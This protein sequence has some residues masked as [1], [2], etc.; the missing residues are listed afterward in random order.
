VTG[1][2]GWV[3]AVGAGRRVDYRVIAAPDFLV[4]GREY[5]VLGD[6]VCP[7]PGAPHLSIARTTT[8]V[9]G[10]LTVVYSTQVVSGQD[11]ADP[12]G[13]SGMVADIRDEQ[14]RPL[15]LIYGF[16]G[17]GGADPTPDA[18]DLNAARAEA[19]RAYRAFL[20]DE[21]GFAV[22]QTAPLQLISSPSTSVLNPTGPLAR[23]ES[24]AATVGGA[25]QGTRR[26]L[27]V[28]LG[29]ILAVAVSVTIAA[30]WLW[31]SSPS[32]PVAITNQAGEQTGVQSTALL[33]TAV[34]PRQGRTVP[35][36]IPMPPAVSL[37]PVGS[38]IPTPPPVAEQSDPACG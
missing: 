5:G 37:P 16:V 30:V 26:N 28:L 23:R 31:P 29:L 36:G 13:P 14:N 25:R 9:A 8:P 18:A 33:P 32:C 4:E 15:Q 22:V 19:W 38:V 20:A 12:S 1:V 21:E 3:F 35:W 7:T 24:P 11:V 17:R 10:P 34:H 6:V 2:F 27:G